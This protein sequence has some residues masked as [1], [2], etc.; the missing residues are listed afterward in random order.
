MNSQA[1]QRY[2]EPIVLITLTW[3]AALARTR[4]SAASSPTRDTEPSESSVWL[5][6]PALLALAQLGFSIVSLY[7][8]VLSQGAAE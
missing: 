8:P 2:F 6:G 1:W 7:W 3:L 4:P 5:A